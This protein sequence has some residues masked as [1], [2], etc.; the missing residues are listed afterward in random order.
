VKLRKT[1][2]CLG[3]I[4]DG[5]AALLPALVSEGASLITGVVKVHNLLDDGTKCLI[6]HYNLMKYH[7]I[8]RPGTYT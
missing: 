4:Q 3:N 7:A 2:T 1:K 6:K 5:S 8:L